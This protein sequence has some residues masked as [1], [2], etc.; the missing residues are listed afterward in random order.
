MISYLVQCFRMHRLHV[1][2]D[3]SALPFQ[4]QVTR[5]GWDGIARARAL[6]YERA[7]RLG[8]RDALLELALWA[9]VAGTLWGTIG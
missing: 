5:Y 8:A 9:F 1:K 6:D 3:P 2:W 4:E 7:H